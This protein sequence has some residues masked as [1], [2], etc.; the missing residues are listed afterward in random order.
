VKTKAVRRMTR[1]TL[2]QD[3]VLKLRAKG[4]TWD[5][6]KWRVGEAR[7]LDILRAPQ[8]TRDAAKARAKGCCERCNRTGASRY[9]V[10]HVTAINK[11]LETYRAPDNVLYLCRSCHVGTHTGWKALTR[12][13]RRQE[14]QLQP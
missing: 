7:A 13:E 9:D 2:M 1:A 10:H 5:Q 3:P 11:N 12:L 14:A 8:T 6:I 4:M